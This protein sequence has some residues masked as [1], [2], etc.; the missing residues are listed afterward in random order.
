MLFDRTYAD[1]EGALRARLHRFT[2]EVVLA[3]TGEQGLARTRLVCEW[4][5]DNEGGS[6]KRIV[7]MDIDGFGMRELTGERVLELG[8]R[9]SANGA[10][11]V[12]TTYSSGF[13]DVYIH[14]VTIG[15]RQVVANHEGLNAQGDLSPDGR[16][17]ALTM[18]HSGNPEIYSKDLAS[19]M[20]RRLTTQPGT[21]ASPAWSPDGTR[22]VFVSDRTGSP[23]IYAVDADGSNLERLT[24]RG[25]Y[26]TAPEWSPDGT[27]IAYCALRSDGF[28]IQVLDLRSGQVTTVTDGGGCEDPSWSPDGRS[29]LYSRK[30]GGRTD[31]YITNV[32]ERKALR[33][34]RGSGRFSDPDWS[35]IP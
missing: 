3:L 24:N 31:L 26:N 1:S 15:S 8:P 32:N 9:W 25:N 6:D 18:S 11:V 29:I 22:I 30:A 21:D 2:D 34:S 27:R 14:N 5:P 35:P 20:I 23:Q 12:Y 16:M 4:D 10:S 17:M 7:V 28:Q 33:I 13:P 19:G